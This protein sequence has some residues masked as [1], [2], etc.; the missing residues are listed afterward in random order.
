[1]SVANP[2]PEYLWRSGTFEGAEREQ[3]LRWKK[4]TVRQRL[5]ALDELCEL[6]RR[7]LARRKAEGRPYIDPHTGKLVKPGN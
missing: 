6:A 1:M 2:D 3:L 5:H 4:L 7:S